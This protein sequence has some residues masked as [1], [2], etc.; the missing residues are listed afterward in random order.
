MKEK[1]Q[2]W[3]KKQIKDDKDIRYPTYE[4]LKAEREEEDAYLLFTIQNSS[5][6]IVKQL[7]TG[8]SKG[9]NR[10]IWDGRY[11]S[12]DPVRLSSRQR[13]PWQSP[14]GGGFALPGE[15]TV[16]LSKTINGVETK[17]VDP[18]PFKLETLGGS[19]LP[20]TDKLALDSYIRKAAELE[21][22]FQGATSILGELGNTMQHIRKATYSVAQPAAELLKDVK[23]F[24]QKLHDMQKT[25]YGDGVASA[26][27]QPQRPSLSS[28]VYG[29]SYEVWSSTSAPTFTQQ[30]QQRIASKQF[31]AALEQLHRLTEVDLKKIEKK[32]EDAKAPYTPGR[33]PMWGGE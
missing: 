32:L 12:K 28:R 15:Y 20:A 23:A 24:E 9:V 7:K 26:I 22:T 17:L 8:V 13:L 27:D 25:F 19:T 5:G 2:E 21:R 14:D 31:K 29:M 16:S 3:E 18:Q 33:L 1:R 4:E 6:E 11:P 10:I 30:E